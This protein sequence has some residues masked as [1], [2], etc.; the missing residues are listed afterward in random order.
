M[1]G[2]LPII[3]IPILRQ[4]SRDRDAREHPPQVE[5]AVRDRRD[6]RKHPA[7]HRDCRD[8]R[9]ARDGKDA[10]EKIVDPC[11]GRKGGVPAAEEVGG[12]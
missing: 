1:K 9:H 12:E 10:P 8:N 11:P 3:K 4:R 6:A 5:R 2:M 7:E